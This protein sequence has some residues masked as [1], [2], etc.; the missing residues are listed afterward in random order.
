[1]AYTQDTRV[2][3]ITSPLGSDTLLLRHLAGQESISRLFRFDLDLVSEQDAIDF[4]AIIGKNLSVKLALEDGKFRHFHGVVSRFAQGTRDRRLVSYRAEI[5]PWLWFLTR[6]S[7]CRIF[8]DKAVPD[9]IKKVFS[10]L[11]FSDFAMRLSG[12]HKP[13]VYC[14]QYRETDFNFVSRLMEEEGIGYFF[15]HEE[16]KHTL[17]LFDSASGNPECPGQADAEYA[18]TEGASRRAGEVEE[19]YVERELH[20]GKYAITDY[21][22]ESP[23]SSLLANTTSAEQIG[24]NDKYEVYDFPTV[25]KTLDEGEERVRLR[26]E[27]EETSAIRIHGRSTCPGFTS[28]HRFTL[29]HHYRTDYNAAYLLTSVEHSANQGVGDQESGSTYSNSF[30]CIPRSIP[31]R[32]ARVTPR[33][34]IQGVQTAVVTGPAGEELYLDKYGRIKVQFHWDREGQ[35]NE[36]TS[37]WVRVSQPIAGK[38]WGAHCHPRIGQEVVVEFLEGDPDRPIV[39]GCVYN[40]EQMPPYD[41]PANS[42][43]TGIKSRSSKGGGGFNEIRLED[44]KGAEE[45]FIH[46]QKDENIVIGN[47]KTEQV[48]KDETITIQNDRTET[49]VG[50]ET[51]SVAKNRTRTVS[52]GETITVLLTRVHSVGVDEMINVGGAQQVTVGG[53]RAVTVGGLQTTNIGASHNES[54]GKDHTVEVSGNESETVGKDHT[55]NVSG[56]ESAIIGK[57]HTVEVSGNESRKIGK[58]LLV[59]VAD[60]ITIQ[61]GDASI[62]M[63]KNGDIVIEGKKISITGSGDVVLKGQKILQN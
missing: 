38:G 4:K 52:M 6:R 54:I 47:N 49:V 21:N 28:G 32:P 56:N 17:V 11:G 58:K 62:Q 20:P 24:G 30:T 50:N 9:I 60:E 3:T 37:C 23:K 44:K 22:F 48:G 45:V 18:T 7:D 53:L 5:V 8:Q 51:L 61:T 26:M 46:A 14:V 12:S 1:M 34:V 43:R 19:W 39:T 13:R 42:T 31:F 35:H 63:K 29:K 33:P 57:D 41:L 27:A 59:D 10:D 15:E 40:A 36:K 2:C 16:S 55:I 25:H